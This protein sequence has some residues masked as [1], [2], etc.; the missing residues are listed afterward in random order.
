MGKK[1]RRNP[2]A[3]KGYALLDIVPGFDIVSN[4]VLIEPDVLAHIN[5]LPTGERRDAF[6]RPCVGEFAWCIAQATYNRYRTA[7]Q[8]GKLVEEAYAAA[9]ASAAGERLQ[10]TDFAEGVQR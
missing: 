6:V 1:S 10:T 3:Q 9:T 5:T 4:Y 2:S 8:E 7:I